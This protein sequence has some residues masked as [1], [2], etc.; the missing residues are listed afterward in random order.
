MQVVG[1]TKTAALDYATQGIRINAVAPGA[2]R[3]DILDYAIKSGS[4]PVEKIE[5]MFPM[6]RMGTPAEIAEA[7]VFL[8]QNQY[9]TGEILSVD[10]GFN[11]A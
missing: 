7:I 8:L 2:I 5:G 3:T 9:C 10:G 11:A 4:Y 1:M 6:R